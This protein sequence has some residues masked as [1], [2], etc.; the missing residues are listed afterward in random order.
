MIFSLKALKYF[1]KS[2]MKML[3]IR[4]K[5][6]KFEKKSGSLKKVKPVSD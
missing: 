5:K 6:L 1:K 3:F 2:L 4:K